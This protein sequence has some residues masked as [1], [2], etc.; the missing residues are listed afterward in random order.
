MATCVILRIEDFILYK[1]TTSGKKQALKEFITGMLLYGFICIWF[2]SA[3]GVFI[4]FACDFA[5]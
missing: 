1:V 2:L 5:L 4:T 3:A